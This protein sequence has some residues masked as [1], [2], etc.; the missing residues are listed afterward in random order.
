M[1]IGITDLTSERLR[2]A[3]S[4]VPRG[5]EFA[6]VGYLG[7]VPSS[8]SR[9]EFLTI[10]GRAAPHDAMFYRAVEPHGM[11]TVGAEPARYVVF[12]F[13]S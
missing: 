9:E 5:T 6:D 1:S 8:S 4:G 12:E 10:G 7:P 13:H 3:E 11:R 2:V